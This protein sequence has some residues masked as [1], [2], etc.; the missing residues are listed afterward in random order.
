MKIKLIFS[1]LPILISLSLFSVGFASWTITNVEKQIFDGDLITDNIDNNEQYIAL[2]SYITFKYYDI[3]FIKIYEKNSATI[4]NTTSLT[5]NYKIDLFNCKQA[6]KEN[7]TFVISFTF[8]HTNIIKNESTK[9][10]FYLI[11]NYL[12]GY[13][14]NLDTTKVALDENTNTHEI[15]LDL[16]SIINNYTG[17]G[18]DDTTRYKTFTLTYNFEY[19]QSENSDFKTDIY[20]CLKNSEFEFIQ[21]I[22]ISK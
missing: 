10:E 5:Y 1:L 17:D 20:P 11:K 3:G 18:T 9:E 13:E 2:D 8:T 7:S 21:I 12:S 19:I 22:N 4:E 15:L 14:T 16:T 6:L